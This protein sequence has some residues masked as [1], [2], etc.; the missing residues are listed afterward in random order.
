MGFDPAQYKTTTKQQWEDAA[1]AW[2]RWGPVLEEWLGDAT[3][4]ML[5][6]AAV[7]SGT[8]RSTSPRSRSWLTSTTC[9]IGQS[10]SLESSP[11]VDLT[12]YSETRLS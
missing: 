3:Q 1:E 7:R 5:D 2:D 10:N 4:L 8:G 6:R 9:F 11:V 12:W